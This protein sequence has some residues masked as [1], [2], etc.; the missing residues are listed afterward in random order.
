VRRVVLRC[1]EVLGVR[2]VW[3]IEGQVGGGGLKWIR[4]GV[5]CIQCVPRA[6]SERNQNN[7]SSLPMENILWYVRRNTEYLIRIDVRC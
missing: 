1:S 3:S 7:R 5:V 2:Q 6:E 4:K